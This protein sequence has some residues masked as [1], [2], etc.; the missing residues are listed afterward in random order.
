[1]KK[2]VLSL[3]AWCSFSVLAFAQERLVKGIV[4]SAEDGR[5]IP[6]ASIKIKEISGVGIATGV[7][8]SFTIKVPDNGKTLVVSSVGFVS[9]G[10]EIKEGTLRIVLQDDAKS[11]EE[12]VVVAYGKQKKES[13]TGSTAGLTAK[14]LQNR[15]FT[16]ITASLQ[17]ASPGLNV[18]ASN[19][20]PGA[21]INVRIRGFGSFSASNTPLYVLDGSVYD[22]N[23][24]DINQNDVE[25]ISV[26][27]DAASSALYGSRGANGV[28]IITTKKGKAGAPTLSA[29]IVQGYSERGIPEYDRVDAYQYYPLVWQGIKNN[30]MFT[31]S[32]ALSELAAATKAS[33]DVYTNLVYNPFNVP[34][35]QLVGTDG[36]LNPNASLLYNDFDW[37]GAMKRPGARTD[38]NVNYSGKVGKSDFYSSI[39][40]LN[41]KGF[42][43]GSDFER[44]NARV[45]VNTEIKPWL[46]AGL[47]LS[48]NTSVSNN[49]SDASTDNANSIVNA[50][51]FSR[52]IGPIYP[53]HAFDANGAAIFNP[54]TNSQW[55]DYGI[56]PGAVARPQGASQGRNLVYETLL[57][58]NITRRSQLG[59]RGYVE[60]SFLKDFKFRPSISMDLRNNNGY[61]YWNPIVGDGQT[62]KGYKYQSNSITRSYT[63]NQVLSYDKT[64][65][66]HTIS[67]LV[68]H[69][70]YDYNYRFFSASRTG[71][72]LEGNTELGNFVTSNSSGGLQDN[73]RI[74]SYFS[75]ASYGY[76]NKYFFDASIR[77]DGSSR[78]AAQ[79][80]WGTF[81]SLGGAWIINRDF[82]TNVKWINDLKL[83]ASYGEVGNNKLDGYY[84]DRAFYDL[85]YNNNTEPGALL[86]SVAN[87]DLKWE[88][89]NTLNLGL[90]FS[91][92]KR[93][94]SGTVEFFKKSVSDLLFS[95]P[96]PLSDPVTSIS[97][98]VGSMY[99]QGLEV[100]L[101][102][103]ILST[104]DFN[105]NLNTNFTV[106]KN[107]VTKLPV[108]TPTIVSG[109]KRR[110]VGYDFYQFWLRQ[111]AGVD[112]TDGSALYIPD[113]TTTIAAADKRTVNGVE[114][115]TKQSN[116]LY[117]RSGSAI[118]DLMGS[119]TNRFNYKNFELSVQINY[120]IGGKFYD[121]QYAGLMGSASYGSALSTDL[122]NA[123]TP[124]N[125][126][127][128][129]PRYDIGNITN[130][131][132]AST[133][134]LIDASYLSIRNVNLSYNFPKALISKLDLS[135][136]RVFVTGENLYLSSKRKGLNPTESFDGTNNTVFPQARI[137]SVGLSASF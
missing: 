4:V 42:I 70:N 95:V 120:Q 136:A 16:N 121:S 134:W 137:L 97:K 50:F 102:G 47:N 12:M 58:E 3:I 75:K 2:L 63:F 79:S 86:T 27:K 21:G 1:M 29:N 32:P 135:G 37:Y 7:D 46:K 51:N 119:F 87:P 104:K 81:Y 106:L 44:F 5:P 28:V 96:Q 30:L 125:T 132:A 128:S 25:S 14:D 80:R 55:Y 34:G 78:F 98:N 82:L 72:T 116:A 66:D 112:P 9:K 93:R 26:L 118:P 19:G 108:E 6:G 129:V 67:A 11:L 101:N 23:I 92:F 103:D 52:S 77:R 53:V 65:G 56:H 105:W 35:A 8:G 122:L 83:R 41:D 124:A 90:D 94:L 13:I 114:Y 126:S 76:K 115:V 89:Q 48:G 17:G 100:Q 127:S 110:E 85:G 61:T 39:G 69:E 62:Q 74:E 49:A 99:N 64:I 57:N 109:T 10:M 33:A 73:D 68:A 107:R 131:N 22:G 43:K 113:Y 18:Q 91:M 123:W 45:N 59:A 24:G 60:I 84:L 36:T 20:Q 111:Y 117:A 133:R 71:L 88:S 54:L 15:T 130:L 38:A 31:A 40:Y